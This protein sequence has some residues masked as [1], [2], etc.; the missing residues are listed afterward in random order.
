MG[1]ERKHLTK[2]AGDDILAVLP[3]SGRGAYQG[4]APGTVLTKG[5]LHVKI[6]IL[7]L[8]SGRRTLKIKQRLITRTLI[9]QLSRG[10]C[11]GMKI[12]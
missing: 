12:P 11:G 3:E 6:D 8:K 5:E 10:I 4:L 7:P 2:R 9:F 1:V